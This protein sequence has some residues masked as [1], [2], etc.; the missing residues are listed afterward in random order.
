[1][2]IEL[3]PHAQGC[4][5]P[6]R[7]RPG[8]RKEAVLGEHAGALRVAVTVAPERGK[9]NA[10]IA[11]VLADAL[12]CRPSQVSLLSGETGRDKRFLIAGLGPEQVRK[13]LGDFTTEDTENTELK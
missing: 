5:L 12:G 2:M 1:A 9:A 4:V 6:V 7:A 10:A 11:R 8:A 13:A 3:S